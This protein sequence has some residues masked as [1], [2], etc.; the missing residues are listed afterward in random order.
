MNGRRGLAWA[1][2]VFTLAMLLLVPLQLVLPRLALPPG[3]GATEA[4]GS[5]WN[6]RLRAAH[7]RGQALGDLD[8]SLAPLQ[9]LAG[10]QQL[11]LRTDSARLVLSRGREAGIAGGTGVVALPPLAGLTLRALL[12]DATLLFAGDRCHE[13]RGRVRVEVT[14]PLD[15][16]PPMIL[17]G[18]PACEGGSGRLAL[19][20]EEARGPLSV[21]ATL[22]IEADGRYRLQALARSDDPAVRVALLAAGFQAAAGGMSRVD[23]GRLGD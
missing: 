22:D 23:E 2:A 10:R 5:V 11:Q 6:G 16:L 21:E 4:T 15:T 1:L 8:A 19:H 20:P 18:A 14:L 13:A 17:S 12:D 9:L 7:W 3:F